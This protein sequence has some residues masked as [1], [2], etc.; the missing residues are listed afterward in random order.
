MNMHMRFILA[1]PLEI[2]Q[3]IIN[4]IM[5]IMEV[6]LPETH[7]IIIKIG[8]LLLMKKIMITIR[9]TTVLLIIIPVVG[10]LRVVM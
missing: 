4:F 7:F 9:N 6:A 3:L 2:A 8:S 1:L 5:I 10:G